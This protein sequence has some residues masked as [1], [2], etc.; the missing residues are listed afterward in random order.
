MNFDI[1]TRKLD[2][3]I[4]F[5]FM[6]ILHVLKTHRQDFASPSLG[7]VDLVKNSGCYALKAKMVCLPY[8]L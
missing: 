1:N 6:S 3:F 7:A 5:S 4:H 2:I 8:S